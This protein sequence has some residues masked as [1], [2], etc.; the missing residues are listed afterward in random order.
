MVPSRRPAALVISMAHD[1]S[2]HVARYHR[3]SARSQK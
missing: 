1:P 2:G 3:D